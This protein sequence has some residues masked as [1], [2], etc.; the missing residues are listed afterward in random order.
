MT[1]LR[2]KNQAKKKKLFPSLIM[3]RNVSWAN[4][5]IEW[6]ISEWSCDTEDNTGVM[7]LKKII[8]AITG[9]N[10]SLK[11]FKTEKKNLCK[12]MYLRN[13]Q[14]SCQPQTLAYSTSVH[15]GKLLTWMPV[16]CSLFP[17]ILE[18]SI[19]QNNGIYLYQKYYPMIH[20]CTM[21]LPKVVSKH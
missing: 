1:V 21:V 16:K 9:I 13:I 15:N 11:C 18:R 3:G 4:Q 17:C 8:L 7:M 20:N 2:K 12:W 14:K 6:M 19:I 5:Q 10:Y